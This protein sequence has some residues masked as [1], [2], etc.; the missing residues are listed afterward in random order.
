MSDYYDL[1]DYRRQVTTDNSD[2]QIWF[3]RGLIWAYAF[4]H[5]E[6]VRCFENVI[7]ADPTCAMGYWGLAF[8]LGP[9]YNK[10]W[11]LFDG[12][13]LAAT[14]TRAHR[15]VLDAKKYAPAASALEGALIDALLCRYPQELPV[16][17]C[18]V[19]NAAYAD[20]I[21]LV[22]EEYP[23]DHDVTALYC[24]ALMNLTPWSLWDLKTGDPT[25]GA[26]TMQVK[27]ALDRVL[28]QDD[29]LC[30]P[31]LLHLY[32]HLM[33]MCGTPEIA[34]PKANCLRGLVPDAGHLE[35]MPSHIDILCGDYRQA[36]ASNTSAIR[37][38]EKY[39]ARQP[40]SHFYNLYRAHDY[41]F[42]MYAAMLSGRSKMA[43][44]TGAELA[45]V[46]TES[47]L[48]VELPPMADW[49][50][51]FVA[52]QMHG[53]IRFGRW[54][55]IIALELPADQT[56]YCVTTAMMHYAKGVA[57]AATGKVTEAE[58]E[59]E[60]FQHSRQAV[61]DSR[62]LFNNRCIDILGVG[63]AMLDG[64]IAYRRG[65]YETAFSHLRAAVDRDDSLPYDE[66]W[67]WMQPTRHALGALLLEQ[68]RVEEA[69]MVYAADLGMEP[70]LPRA[71]RHP[72]N[73]WAS[74]GYHECLVKLGRK[75]EARAFASQ[76]KYCLARA[77]VPIKSSCFCRLETD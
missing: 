63:E 21:T 49:L 23:D 11:Q 60:L 54:N 68:G 25:P 73:V 7:A 30:H 62:M 9:N 37:A 51:G 20:A 3:S 50:E 18:S 15:A 13:D 46:L 32:I 59:R 41:H 12:D 14:T 8:A 38:D 67:G 40:T 31:G 77:D 71:L 52:M 55:D 28:D 33:E 45:R 19:W 74:H 44:E 22:Y 16:G 66:P 42:R 4:N 35:H 56:L 69:F 76:L 17:D 53:L 1:G 65:E 61:P 36:I 64:E 58:E 10:P 29:A 34:L 6:S 75:A 2:A 5:E 48:R 24:D 72:M 39:L 26:K 27:K 70:T 57:F 43:L 47:I